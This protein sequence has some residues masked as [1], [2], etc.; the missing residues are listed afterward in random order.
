MRPGFLRFSDFLAQG[1]IVWQALDPQALVA[2]ARGKRG[3]ALGSLFTDPMA[4]AKALGGLRSDFAARLRV[5]EFRPLERLHR[6]GLLAKGLA[7]PEYWTYCTE[8]DLGLYKAAKASRLT[9]DMKA[10]LRV[11]QEDAPISRQRLLAL[12]DLSRPTTAAA[13]RKLYEGLHVTR[14]WD[15]RYRPVADIKI[16]REDARREVLRRIIRS[17]GGTSAEALA[18]YTRFEYNMGETPLRLRGLEAEGLP[19]KS[20]PA[21][22]AA[23]WLLAVNDGLRRA[24]R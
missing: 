13:L 16:S 11:I 14:D 1:R 10:V 9:K 6:G 23:T 15:N 22:S 7:I 5:K 4:A 17:L 24:A 18:A 2:C 12:S 8:E 21:P 20:L 3:V 19:A